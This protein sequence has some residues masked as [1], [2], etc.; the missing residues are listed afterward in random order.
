MWLSFDPHIFL[1]TCWSIF[2]DFTTYNPWGYK[3]INTNGG[4][5]SEVTGHDSKVIVAGRRL[6]LRNLDTIYKK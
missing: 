3:P 1:P 6:L 5:D 4:G 2:I